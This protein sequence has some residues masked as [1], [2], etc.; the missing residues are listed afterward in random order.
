MINQS[1]LSGLRCNFGSQI[2][3]RVYLY[4]G[5]VGLSNSIHNLTRLFP[6]LSRRLFIFLDLLLIFSDLVQQVESFPDGL[7][8]LLDVDPEWEGG[9]VGWEVDQQPI[10]LFLEVVIL[11][12]GLLVLSGDD[13]SGFVGWGGTGI[14]VFVVASEE[15]GS[16]GW[17]YA[18]AVVSDS[19]LDVHDEVVRINYNKD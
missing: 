19:V 13:G 17:T 9:G 15:D 18:L 2:S 14:S 7:I 16:F 6:Q 12:H 10:D 3:L 5:C 8:P 1:T 11:D 4:N